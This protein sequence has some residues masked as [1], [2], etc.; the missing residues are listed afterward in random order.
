[1]S[2]ANVVQR[3]CAKVADCSRDGYPVD[4]YTLMHIC[5]LISFLINGLLVCVL[6][7]ANGYMCTEV[8]PVGN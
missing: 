7:C 8:E 1:M 2:D 4:G 6:I 5:W 3:S